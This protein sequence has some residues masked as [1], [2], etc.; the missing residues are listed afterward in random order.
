MNRKRGGIMSNPSYQIRPM[1]KNEVQTA[2]DLAAAEGWNP[3]RHDAALFF[4]ADPQGFLAGFL[5]GQLIATISAVRYGQGF[6]FTGF[7]IV[8]PEFRGRGYGWKLWQAAM[9]RLAGYNVGLDGVLAQQNNYKKSGFQLAYRNI[10]YQAQLAARMGKSSNVVDLI[11]LPFETVVDYDSRCFFT[12]RPEFLRLWIAQPAGRALACVSGGQLQGYGVIR[13]CQSGCKVG[14]LFADDPAIADR[15]FMALAAYTEKQPVFLDVPEPN[16]AA[17]A[18][19]EQY[20]MQPIFE[21]ARMYTG[22]APALDLSK[23]FGVTSFELG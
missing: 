22:P 12:P 4:A 20:K 17:V 14:P 15:L 9:E 23:V 10:R 18:L 6:G 16:S 2:V 5:D 3:G 7:Y 19:A 1:T 13:Q 21:T 11:D 8:K